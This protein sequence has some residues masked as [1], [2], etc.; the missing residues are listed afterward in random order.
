MNDPAPSVRRLALGDLDAELRHTR[1]LLERL[2]DEQLVWKPHA[3]SFSLGALATHIATLPAW[4][5]SIVQED[6]FDI[7]AP[8]PKNDPLPGREAVLEAFDRNSAA[9]REALDAADD[10][11]LARRWELRMGEAVSMA[12]PKHAVL[13]SIGINH[14]I[15]HRGQLSVYLRLLDVPLPGMYGP[16]ADE[17]GGF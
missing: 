17:R 13:R 12:A 3:K 2:P 5:V 9:F 7:G 1:A 6:F 10:E 4:L 15:H 16:S 14:I 11:V 8:L